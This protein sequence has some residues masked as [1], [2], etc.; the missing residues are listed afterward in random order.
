MGL[1]IPLETLAK[2]PNRSRILVGSGVDL[3][4]IPTPITKTGA[5]KETKLSLLVPVF[6][7]GMKTLWISP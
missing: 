4:E 1:A 7:L 5:D 2:I 6:P 3:G